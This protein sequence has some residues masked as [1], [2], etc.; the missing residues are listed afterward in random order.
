MAE[1]GKEELTFDTLPAKVLENC[2]RTARVIIISELEKRLNKDKKYRTE[3][4]KILCEFLPKRMD[5]EM[6]DYSESKKYYQSLNYSRVRIGHKQFIKKILNNSVF[7]KLLAQIFD[8]E[9]LYNSQKARKNERSPISFE[10]RKQILEKVLLDYK[11]K[12]LCFNQ[13]QECF[14]E[15]S[16][17]LE[18][19]H[20]IE[21][22]E[23]IE[24]PAPTMK[25]FPLIPIPLKPTE[26]SKY[27][28]SQLLGN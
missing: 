21:E 26:Y 25:I 7:Q 2:Q 15:S 14:N 9:S 19:F 3:L 22:K 20:N 17:I 11:A 24:L 5:E 12:F 16:T 1:S 10:K 13:K 28:A 27:M 18:S 23:V 4:H 8:S 6:G